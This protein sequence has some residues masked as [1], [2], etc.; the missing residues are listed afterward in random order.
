VK[1]KWYLDGDLVTEDKQ[2][3]SG[4]TD[5]ATS[6]ISL[7]V[8]EYYTLKCEATVYDEEHNTDQDYRSV[9]GRFVSGGDCKIS[10][11]TFDYYSYLTE[12]KKGWVETEVENTGGR[13][14]TLTVRL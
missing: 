14:G 8:D 13:S 6:D 9:S 4:R 1:F 10:V 7:A 5:E 11:N 12:G 3:V 2:Y